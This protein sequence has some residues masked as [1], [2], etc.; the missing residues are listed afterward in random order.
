LA[1]A[2]I[3]SVVPGYHVAVGVPPSV[4]IVATKFVAVEVVGGVVW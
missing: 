4:V 2:V 1:V 3:A